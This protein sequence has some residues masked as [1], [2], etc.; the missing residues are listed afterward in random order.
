LIIKLL[1]ILG[2]VNIGYVQ[3]VPLGNS[4]W[5]IGYHVAENYTRNGYATE[6]VMAFVP[7]IANLLGITHIWGICRGDNIASRKVLEKCSFKLQN[8]SIG[9]YKGAQHEVYKYLYSI[10]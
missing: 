2:G 1:F 3:A 4:E 6:A 10:T 7:V 8:K 5:E 9:N